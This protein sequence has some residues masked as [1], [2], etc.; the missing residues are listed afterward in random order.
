MMYWHRNRQT[1]EMK[2]N[3]VYENLVYESLGIDDQRGNKGLLKKLC[4]CT[5][6]LERNGGWG[7]MTS[8]SQKA[9]INGK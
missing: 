8:I 7:D 3:L 2:Q 1:V 5:I 9:S 6:K 4:Q